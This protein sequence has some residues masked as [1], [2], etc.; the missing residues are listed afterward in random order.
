MSELEQA[1]DKNDEAW[2]EFYLRLWQ[3]LYLQ[4]YGIFGK[5]VSD[6]QQKKTK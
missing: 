6:Y 4:F 1:K 2:R 5:A 3:K